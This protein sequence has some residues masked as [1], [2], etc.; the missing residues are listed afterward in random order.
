[1][2]IIFGTIIRY[3]IADDSHNCQ[4]RLPSG[5]RFQTPVCTRHDYNEAEVMHV[6]LGGLLILLPFACALQA[7]TDAVPV[8]PAK[9]PRVAV[10]DERYASYNVEM[11]EVTGGSFWKPYSADAKNGRSQQPVPQDSAPAGMDPNMYQYRPP[12]DLTNPRLR[13]LAAAL[14]FRPPCTFRIRMETRLSLSNME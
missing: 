8:D 3:Y 4:N 10:V 14:G 7:Q 1:L 2:A 13:K 6:R 11:A 9:M 12:V 5:P